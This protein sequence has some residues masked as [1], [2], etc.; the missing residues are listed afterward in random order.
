MRC[1]WL[2]GDYRSSNDV[3]V[4]DADRMGGE[5]MFG[6]GMQELLIIAVVGLLLFGER[7]PEVARTAGKYYT[8]FRQQISDI[9]SQISMSDF[10]SPGSSRSSSSSYAPTSA[11]ETYDDYDTPTAPKFEPPPVE[12]PPPPLKPPAETK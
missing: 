3:A 5:L 12:S 10:S 2:S 7:L 6:L 11:P 8:K 4:G 1:D 9:Q